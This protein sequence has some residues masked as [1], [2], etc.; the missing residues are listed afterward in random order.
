MPSA[1]LMQPPALRAAARVRRVGS[2][3][4]SALRASGGVTR[5]LRG[6]EATPFQL[7]GD[8][9][10]G[11]TIIW[12][13]CDGPDHPRAV[14]LDAP[15]AFDVLDIDAGTENAHSIPVQTIGGC[16]SWH[17]DACET[18]S[19]AIL[20]LMSRSI[21]HG[22][23]MMW[24]GQAPLFP[25]SH[26]ADSALALARACGQGDTQAFVRHAAHLLGVG[27]GLTPSGDDFVGAALFAMRSMHAHGDATRI[28]A[29]DE[30]ARIG[31]RHDASHWVAAAEQVIALAHTRT[32]A[33]SA[34]LLADLARGQSYA[35]LHDFAAALTRGDA[36]AAFTHA[37]AVTSIGASSGWDMLAGFMA[38]LRG[39]AGPVTPENTRAIS[40]PSAHHITHS[41]SP[42]F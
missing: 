28:G 14:L 32:H 8:R 3:A 4:R 19:R 16:G 24:A 6:F 42:H 26:R 2:L 38:A 25:L 20:G 27:A 29:S 12:V 34:A 21:P 23:A 30:G 39:S 10:A 40:R 1:A 11:D 33:I 15:G 22:F 5:P 7:A 31:T 36:P 41:T 37:A 13:G 9:L 17:D 18:A 35:A